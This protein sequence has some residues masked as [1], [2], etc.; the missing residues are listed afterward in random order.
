LKEISKKV[1]DIETE[2]KVAN[3]LFDENLR[4]SVT[5]ISSLLTTIGKK[6]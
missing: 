3:N 5:E 6:L 2:M 4:K 1:E